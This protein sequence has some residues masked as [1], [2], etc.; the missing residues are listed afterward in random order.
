M[1]RNSR[2]EVLFDHDDLSI[3]NRLIVAKKSLKGKTQTQDLI[4]ITNLSPKSIIFHLKRLKKFGSI[5]IKR[6][7]KDKFREKKIE[8]T[9]MG[10][11]IWYFFHQNIMDK[12][13]KND[14]EIVMKDILKEQGH[15]WEKI[16][17]IIL[18]L[19]K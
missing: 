10:V 9:K 1:K 13:D 4:E 14:I 18:D 5:S 6:K 19:K 12:N 2:S 17:K 8:V 11:L 15:D 3:L 7:E 16:K